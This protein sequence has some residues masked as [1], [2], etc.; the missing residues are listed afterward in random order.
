MTQNE[1]KFTDKMLVVW[2]GLE[3]LERGRKRR[4]QPA[5]TRLSDLVAK[6]LTLNLFSWFYLYEQAKRALTFYLRI[7]E[8]NI[9]SRLC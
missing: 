6:L 7:V 9:R 5:A 4:L 2:V 8:T 3:P 1:V